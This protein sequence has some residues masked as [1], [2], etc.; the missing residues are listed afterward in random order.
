MYLLTS[1]DRAGHFRGEAIHP[2]KLDACPMSG[3]SLAEA[4]SSV[5]VAWETNGQVYFRRIDPKSEDV[6]PPVAPPGNSGTRKHPA[7]AG[8]AAA[9][10][11]WSG[12]RG[13]AGRK[14]GRWYGRC[15][16]GPGV[17]TEQRGRIEGG[18]PVWGLPT[19]VARPDGT[20]IIV[21]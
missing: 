10:R 7:V 21:R 6:M 8:N 3:A 19:V 11:S 5:L 4:G 15:S 2:W 16:I 13:L 14:G 20:F 17:P 1:N 18:V 9:R 12:P